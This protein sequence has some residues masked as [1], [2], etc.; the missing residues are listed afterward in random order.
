MLNSILLFLV[1][2]VIVGPITSQIDA[3]LKQA[4]APAALV[5]SVN[6]CVN[7]ALPD[8]AKRIASQPSQGISLA[9]EIWLQGG[10]FEGAI[11]KA[12]PECA[13]L[14]QAAKPFYRGTGSSS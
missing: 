1:Q 3:R 7:A 11:L 8:L 5:S 14:L 2:L 10:G 4:Q 13:P 12:A 9:A 6:S